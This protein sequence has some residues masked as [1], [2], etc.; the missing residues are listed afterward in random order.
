MKFKIIFFVLAAILSIGSS[1]ITKAGNKAY[2]LTNANI[3]YFDNTATPN[4]QPI[5]CSTNYTGAPLCSNFDLYSS[6]DAAHPDICLVEETVYLY[7]K[8]N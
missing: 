5:T 4:C 3:Y 6:R 8:P 7:H 1:F 2:T